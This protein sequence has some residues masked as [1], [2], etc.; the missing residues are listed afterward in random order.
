MKSKITMTLMVVYDANGVKIE[1]LEN[2]LRSSM[3]TLIG[4]GGLTGS[5][6]AEVD[7]YDLDFQIEEDIR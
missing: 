6:A 1:D 3:G 7:L 2:I 4:D 5:S